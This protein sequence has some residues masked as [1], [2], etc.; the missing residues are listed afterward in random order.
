MVHGHRTAATFDPGQTRCSLHAALMQPRVL[1]SLLGQIGWRTCWAFLSTC[2]DFRRIF[3]YSDLRDVILS[4]FVPGFRASLRSSDPSRFQTVPVTLTDL[5]LLMISQTVIVH[6]Y[7]MHALTCI[8]SD[9]DQMTQERTSKLSSLALAHSRFVLLVQALAHSSTLAPPLDREEIDCRPP[10]MEPSLRQLKF[11][12]PLSPASPPINANSEVPRRGRRALV[13]TGKL[14]VATRSL[15]RPASRLS[16]FRS[17]KIPP[18]P[19]SEPRSL[20]HYSSA[21]RHSL[22]RASESDEWGTQQP[23]E[24]PHRRFASD[25]RSSDSSPPSSPSP[26]FSR[27]STIGASSPTRRG[28]S[29][30]DLSLATS[31]TRA[32]VLRVFVPCAALDLNSD[33]IASCE[34][35]LYEAGLWDHLSTGDV[36]CNLG[37]LPPHSSEEPSGSSDSSFESAAAANEQKGNRR[38][39]LLFNGQSLVPFSPPEPI[40]LSN[41]FILP[42][43]FYYL[44][45]MPPRTNPVFTVRAFPPC[46]SVPQMRLVSSTVRVRSPHSPFGYAMAKKVVWT[47]RVWRQVTQDD[48]I[49]YGW[50]GEWV[51]EGE[52]T[53]EGQKVLLDCLRGVKGP[54]REW[55]LVREKSTGETLW[56]R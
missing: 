42:S 13:L 36:V 32:P 46:G 18:P 53:R 9:V 51:L 7:P 11:P 21:W 3:S 47:A 41:P 24:R 43:P 44:P 38:K 20:K 56:F 14:P 33:S 40:P 52:G 19:V 23:L 50:Q 28:I 49:G 39:W 35:Q 4:C 22:M 6:R 27:N 25:N 5:N 55:E 12:A 29:Y 2:S 10:P 1:A 48:E 54:M 45:I 15:S 8:S 17:S 34:D 26:T 30:H 31:R 37:Y 16:L